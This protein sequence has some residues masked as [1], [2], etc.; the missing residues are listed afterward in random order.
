M[1]ELFAGDAQIQTKKPTDCPPRN[2]RHGARKSAKKIL[3][4]PKN[5]HVSRRKTNPN[6]Q[7][8]GPEHEPPSIEPKPEQFER[9]IALN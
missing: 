4:N 2:S 8:S 3:V 7:R 5:S 9:K 1:L 6:T